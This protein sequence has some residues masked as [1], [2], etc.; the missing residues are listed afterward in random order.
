HPNVALHLESLAGLHLSRGEVEAAWP[1]VRAAV[2]LRRRVLPEGHPELVRGLLLLALVQTLRSE[3]EAAL[4][5]V[6]EVARL[7]EG[8]FGVV[9]PLAL[10]DQRLLHV[11]KTHMTLDLALSLGTGPLAGSAPVV[12]QLFDLVLRRKGLV[13]RAEAAQHEAV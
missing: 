2:E 8:Q 9:F 10:E 11:A 13:T 12:R 7:E 5:T 4:G 6:L 3:G 1:L